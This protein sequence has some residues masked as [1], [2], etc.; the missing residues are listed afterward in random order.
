MRS[1]CRH[2]SSSVAIRMSNFAIGDSCWISLVIENKS[3]LNCE[4]RYLATNRS[5]SG[6]AFAF[7]VLP[8]GIENLPTKQVRAALGEEQASVCSAWVR[9]SS[10]KDITSLPQNATKFQIEPGRE[11]LV[12]AL[13]VCVYL[14]APPP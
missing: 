5:A 14:S 3:P 13:C 8:S 2:L 9:L 4:A 10:V 11:A 6:S 1:Q 12:N 7:V